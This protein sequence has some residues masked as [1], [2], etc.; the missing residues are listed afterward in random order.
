MALNF[1]EEYKDSTS[2]PDWQLWKQLQNGELKG[3][4]ILFRRYHEDLF[5]YALKLCKDKST[6]ED[7]VQDTFLSIWNQRKSL[8][9]V[10]SIKPYLLTALR[11]KVYNHY[12]KERLILGLFDE[13]WQIEAVQFSTE[14]ILILEQKRIE[15]RNRLSKALN[16]LPAR[17]REVIYL[18]FYEGMSY[19]EIQEILSLEY[20]T[21]R[22]YIHEGLK[23][24]RS[25]LENYSAAIFLAATASLL[26]LLVIFLF[27]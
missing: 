10:H 8:D 2:F 18:K 24:L 5:Y 27:G 6:A 14:E 9:N 15:V 19:T 13:S 11:N 25:I 22:N 26:T 7:F 3:L 16:R 1:N 12:N 23:Q 21:I 17:Q 20:Q 4:E